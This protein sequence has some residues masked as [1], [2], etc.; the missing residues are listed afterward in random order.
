MSEWKIYYS[1]GKTY[2]S[3]DGD[4][5][6][7]PR[8]DVQ[9]VVQDGGIQSGKTAYFWNPEIGWNACDWPGL[10]DYLQSFDGP[11]SVIFGRS[12]RDEE[13]WETMKRA[14]VERDEAKV[15]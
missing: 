13:F 15:G 10:W 9:V 7:A 11:Q 2:S 3:E 6:H 5:F 8:V 12:I 4:A 1:G 14:E